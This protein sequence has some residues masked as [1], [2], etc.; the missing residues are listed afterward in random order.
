LDYVRKL[1]IIAVTCVA[2]N[3]FSS[4]CLPCAFT[5]KG[6]TVEFGI[7]LSTRFPR[8]ILNTDSMLVISLWIWISFSNAKNINYFIYHDHSY[9]T[10]INR[11]FRERKT[12]KTL[13]E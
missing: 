2:P 11:M 1:P 12:N 10:A 7:I 8:S 4:H 6:N 9:F 3:V 5:R 13:N